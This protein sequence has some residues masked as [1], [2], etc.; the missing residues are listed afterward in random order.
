MT[1]RQVEIDEALAKAAECELIGNLAADPDKRRAYR[2]LAEGFWTAAR[3]MQ[4]RQPQ[5]DECRDRS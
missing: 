1:G 4:T 3:S 5:D 2:T